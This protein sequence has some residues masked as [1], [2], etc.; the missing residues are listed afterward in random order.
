VQMLDR[1]RNLSR[2]G[3]CAASMLGAVFAGMWPLTLPAG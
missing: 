3:H 2:G 1:H